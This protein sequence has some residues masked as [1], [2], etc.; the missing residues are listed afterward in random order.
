VSYGYAENGHI[1]WVVNFWNNGRTWVY[2]LTEGLWHERA[3]WNASTSA[4]TKYLPWYGTFIPEWG[5]NGT[6]IVG[7]PVSGTLYQQSL[8]YYDDNGALIQYTR[9]FPHLINEDQYHY[10]HR[11]EILLEQGAQSSSAPLP[12]I[13][14][15]WSDDHGHTFNDAIGR[16]K[17]AAPSG[18]YTQRV[19]F[20]RLGKSRDR[21]YR[22]GITA[23]SK[24]A[25]IDTYLESTPGFA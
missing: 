11:L 19:A 22:V 8:N 7:D 15:D 16:F 14:L 23:K 18:N 24:V 6:H 3:G 9:A 5:A 12:L 21:V 17:N 1:F 20:R 2:D 13:G 10:D 4:Y 25:L